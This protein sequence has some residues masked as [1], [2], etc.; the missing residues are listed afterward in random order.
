MKALLVVFLCLPACSI[1][2]GLSVHPESLDAPEF[3]APNP[4]GILGAEYT[5]GRYTGFCEHRSSIPYTE[6]GYG[7]NECGV[8]ISLDSLGVTFP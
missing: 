1:Y 2:T 7:L 3:N 4:I 5:K 8:K 6:E